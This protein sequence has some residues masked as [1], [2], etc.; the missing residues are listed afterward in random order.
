MSQPPPPP[1]QAPPIVRPQSTLPARYTRRHKGSWW[2]IL[3]SA[4]TLTLGLLWYLGPRTEGTLPNTNK[5]AIESLVAE[6]L[7]SNK[8]NIKSWGKPFS[9][10]GDKLYLGSIAKNHQ[11]TVEGIISR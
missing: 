4:L 11:Y 7:G 2:L 3:I 5:R 6:E 8:W 1:P 10:D 9:L